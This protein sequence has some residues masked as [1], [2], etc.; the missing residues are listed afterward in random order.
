MKVKDLKGTK[1]LVYAV[2]WHTSKQ[3]ESLMTEVRILYHPATIERRTTEAIAF[4]IYAQANSRGSCEYRGWSWCMPMNH[5]LI[6][7]RVATIKRK[8]IERNKELLEFTR[9]LRTRQLIK[10]K[11]AIQRLQ[12]G[13]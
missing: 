13:Y 8:T 9:S 4:Q 10:E 1:A 7:E 6:K 3:R 5:G 2:R 12:R 11:V